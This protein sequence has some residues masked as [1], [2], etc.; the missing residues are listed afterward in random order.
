[1]LTLTRGV[2]DGIR[3]GDEFVIRVH[4]IGRGK[5]ELA[6][7]VPRSVRV[8]RGEIKD[9]FRPTPHMKAAPAAG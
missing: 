5:V 1:M 7:D 9:G 6:L 8:T 2:G 3:I 4:K